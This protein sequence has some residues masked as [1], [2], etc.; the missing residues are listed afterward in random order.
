[1]KSFHSIYAV[2]LGIFLLIYFPA[3]AQAP[4]PPKSASEIHH[5]IKKLQ[6]LGS[7]LYVAAH[8][9]DE[10]TRLLAYMAGEKGYRTAY[11]SMTRGDGGQ[12]SLGD[13]KGP[14]LGMLRTQ[15]LLAARRIDGAEQ[16]FT[17]AYD[18]GYS[19]NHEETLKI[20]DK[21]K[22]LSDVVW[23]IRKFQP[24]VIITRF[25]GPEK[26]GGGHGHHT[27]SAML[28]QEAFDLAADPKAYPEQLEHV[29]T[30][31]AKRLLWNAW[32]FGR[33]RDQQFENAIQVDIGTYSPLLGKSFGEIGSAARSMHKCQDFGM[34][35]LRGEL[36][37]WLQHEKGDQT[38]TD[39]FARVDATWGRI[40]EN[41][42]GKLL[43]KAYNDFRPADPTATIPTLI[44]ALKAMEGKEGYWYD[45]KRKEIQKAILY[46]AGIWFEVNSK[47]PLVAVGDSVEMTGQIIKRSAYPAKLVSVNFGAKNQTE[48]MNLQLANDNKLVNIE[49]SYIPDDA[50]PGQPYW[51]VN[52]QEK[53]V[54]NVDDRKLI[55]LPQNPGAINTTWKFEI[56]GI[57]FDYS[58]PVVHKYVDRKIGE[59][60]RPF[61]FAPPITIN[62]PQA[63]YLFSNNK[64]QEVQLQVKS[65]A[66][67]SEVN[68]SI[69]KPEGWKISPS[70]FDLSF[71]KK[72]E[73]KTV[74]VSVTPPDYQSVGE[75]KFVAKTNNFEG[76]HSQKMI[77]YNHIPAQ[78]VFDPAA[79]RL[80]KVDLETRGELIGYIKA[81]DEETPT[82]LEQ[83]GYKVDMLE[84]EEILTDNLSKYDAV[85]AGSRSYY[86][87][88]RMPFHKE[89]IL[90]YV[91]NGGTYIVQYNK[92]Y[93]LRQE[94]P[95]P[96]PIKL[97]RDRVTDEESEVKFLTPDHPILNSPNKISKKDFEGWIQER[98]L[99]FANEWDDNYTPLLSW[100]DP[101]EDPKNG[102][103]LVTKYGEGYFIYTSISWFREL[104]AGVPGAY[105]LFA[106]LI[107]IGKDA[108]AEKEMNPQESEK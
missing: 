48:M 82:N 44:K 52:K 101:G 71:S 32:R 21:D 2:I 67:K 90:E 19:K 105:R 11:L 50:T 6:V 8:P 66:N 3:S 23:A 22:V 43:T 40:G 18:F 65:F 77:D 73:E 75:L 28:A 39:L 103:L 63:I 61:L 86:I 42:I 92:T 99:Y 79:A 17:R 102:S 64:E 81:V 33:G 46:C 27:S 76:S 26:G 35:S 98:G 68:I 10:N 57:T 41:K 1:M 87:R 54:F 34:F 62:L 4:L 94:Q 55:G 29:S 59:L 108:E 104:P 14:Y 93:D 100:N 88:K 72:G 80:V 47:D 83:I 51:L 107:S 5:S 78:M 38:T 96:Y 37:E 9:D 30:W 60:Y 20:W 85:I 16:M 74:S 89:Q 97:S 53:G 91:K 56:D 24:D 15:E 95:G 58:I 70:N 7:V 13:E 12:N 69:E 31:Q 25:P 84:D 106:N 49:K 45:L 36:K